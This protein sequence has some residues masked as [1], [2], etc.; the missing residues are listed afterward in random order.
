MKKIPP[1][2]NVKE[3]AIDEKVKKRKNEKYS[4]QTNG[5]AEEMRKRK[6]NNKIYKKKN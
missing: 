6:R 4:Q 5:K 1:K 3:K 2:N